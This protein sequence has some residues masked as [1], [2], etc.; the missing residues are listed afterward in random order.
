MLRDVTSGNHVDIEKLLIVDG[1]MI[2]GTYYNAGDR[3]RT[4]MHRST[5]EL[6]TKLV[7]SGDITDPDDRVSLGI[8]K[9]Q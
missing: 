8:R 6:T 7:T 2:Y 1:S 3:A 9:L 4:I 5:T